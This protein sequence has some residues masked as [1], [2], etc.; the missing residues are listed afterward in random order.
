MLLIRCKRKSKL[1]FIAAISF[2]FILFSGGVLA[3]NGENLISQPTARP[4]SSNIE[5]TDRY[6]NAREKIINEI[7]NC[8]NA[9]K[10]AT[11][12]T[13]GVAAASSVSN[14]ETTLKAAEESGANFD[15]IAKATSSVFDTCH[16]GF[17]SACMSNQQFVPRQVEQ[18]HNQEKERANNLAATDTAHS[19][20][21]QEIANANEERAQAAGGELKKDCDSF[22]A[23]VLEML[24]LVKEVRKQR[25]ANVS[26]IETIVLGVVGAG[27]GFMAGVL[28]KELVDGAA[29]EEEKKKEIEKFQKKVKECEGK[30]NEGLCAGYFVEH[31]AVERYKAKKEGCAKFNSSYCGSPLAK[32]SD[33]HPGL[34][35]NSQYCTLIHARIQCA[36]LKESNRPACQWLANIDES[37]DCKKNPLAS[38]CLPQYT[39]TD[40]FQAVC[41]EHGFQKDDGN[42][43]DV[44]CQNI[45]VTN[46]FTP[47]FEKNS[48]KPVG[49]NPITAASVLHKGAWPPDSPPAVDS[50]SVVTR[51]QVS[52]LGENKESERSE[53]VLLIF[54]DDQQS[55]KSSRALAAQEDLSD[56]YVDV[57][58]VVSAERKLCNQGVLYNCDR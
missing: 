31:C 34:N 12:L 55:Q 58:S 4:I 38:D 27:V 49:V 6:T 25:Q 47:H 7:R 8:N 52:H 3:A 37:E 40:S 43:G 57:F 14:P 15:Q 21:Y 30:M 23:G 44:V 28:V 53:G 9:Y 18:H 41:E 16:A 29:K 2:I 46:T 56:Q 22:K 45:L 48:G 1:A 51:S 11:A 26:L 32:A 54:A 42:Y 17:E 5:G 36:D 35:E 33:V 19:Q 10:G 13:Q 39:S 24:T 20:Y 50:P